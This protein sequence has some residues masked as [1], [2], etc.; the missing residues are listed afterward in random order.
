MQW[1]VR[2]GEVPGADWFNSHHV[3]IRTTN[4]HSLCQLN[5]II[6]GYNLKH[7]YGLQRELLMW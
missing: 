4:I 2:Y 5:P 7:R 6:V 3:T 1:I